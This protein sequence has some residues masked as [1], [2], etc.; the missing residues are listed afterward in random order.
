MLIG[1]SCVQARDSNAEFKSKME[2]PAFE[3][4]RKLVAV[5]EIMVLALQRVK[6]SESKNA[7]PAVEQSSSPYGGIGAVLTKNEQTDEIVIQKCM[8]E[9]PALKAGL[10]KNDV[11][12]A[13]DDLSV[14]GKKLDDVV[15]QVRGKV[16]TSVKFTIRRNGG[17]PEKIRIERTLIQVAATPSP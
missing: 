12:I 4:V 7:K 10:R 6:E 3:N 8:D 2:E 17:P 16:G 11:V 13:I 14:S 1:M 15:A 5:T 9:S